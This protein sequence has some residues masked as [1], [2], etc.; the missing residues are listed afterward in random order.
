MCEEK[1]EKTS[2]IRQSKLLIETN[3]P[4]PIPLNKKEAQSKGPQG[5]RGEGRVVKAR[6]EKGWREDT[7]ASRNMGNLASDLRRSVTNYNPLLFVSFVYLV[8]TALYYSYVL[9][10]MN[11]ASARQ[12][13]TELSRRAT[14]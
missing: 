5:G 1:N 2:T 14:W 13:K 12:V 11:P 7:K 10:L 6:Q 9:I 3:L 8:G 4:R